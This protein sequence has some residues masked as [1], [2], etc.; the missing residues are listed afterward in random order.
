[1]MQLIFLFLV[2]GDTGYG[3]F[4]NARRY[5]RKLEERGIA[6]VCFED[7]IISKN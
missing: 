3:D 5:V 7:K 6:G 4:N 2:D 1:M